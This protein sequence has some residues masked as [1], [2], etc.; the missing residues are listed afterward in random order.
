MVVLT[1]Q[2]DDFVF[3]GQGVT[4][5]IWQTNVGYPNWV[6]RG[7]FPY[8][9]VESDWQHTHKWKVVILLRSNNKKVGQFTLDTVSLINNKIIK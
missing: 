5:L 1:C 8:L 3:T 6:T 2:L 7:L 4:F 9:G